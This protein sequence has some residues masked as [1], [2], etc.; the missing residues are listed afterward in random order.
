M[1]VDVVSELSLLTVVVDV[2]VPVDVV[3][4][5]PDVIVFEST[6]FPALEKEG[7][8]TKEHTSDTQ[9]SAHSR[10]VCEI[11]RRFGNSF[12]FGVVVRVFIIHYSRSFFLKT[13]LADGI[14]SSFF[15]HAFFASSPILPMNGHGVPAIHIA[16]KI[17]AS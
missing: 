7:R 8:N 9:N 11:G 10:N 16:S 15:S 12:F 14:I 13:L 6:P 4:V 5:V 17:R 3:V 2:A 1:V